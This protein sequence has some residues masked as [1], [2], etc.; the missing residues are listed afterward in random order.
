MNSTN[1]RHPR[2]DL[3][4]AFTNPL[5]FS[6]MA[7]LSGAESLTFKYARDFLDTT[8][9]TLSKHISALEELGYVQVS[10]GF[11]GKFPQTSIKLSGAGKRA[12][13][14]HLDVLRAIAQ[15]GPA[16]AGPPPS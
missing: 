8:D 14:D 7:A 13:R 12:W 1:R 4:P 3:N 11:A 2:L 10:K 15:S 6:L 5:R 16:P 9:S